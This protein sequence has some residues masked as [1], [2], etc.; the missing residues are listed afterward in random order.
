[1][2]EEQHSSHSVDGDPLGID[3]LTVDYDYLRYKISDYIKS[4]QIQ[5]D[6]LCKRQYDLIE[7]DI[8]EG[9]LDK[10]V[11]DFKDLLAK[12]EELD[13]YFEMLKQLET[14]TGSFK[15]RLATISAE[16]KAIKADGS[17]R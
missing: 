4:I 2:A 1:M 16:Y 9:I 12:C 13:N 14:I 11:Q 7:D 10:N 8:I 6:E 5:T 17:S 15:K 3:K